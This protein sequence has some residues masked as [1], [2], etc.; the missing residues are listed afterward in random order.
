MES[1]GSGVRAGKG[2]GGINA[3]DAY[4]TMAWVCTPSGILLFSPYPTVSL[5]RP[6]EQRV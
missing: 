2:N 1:V 6:P 5:H 4:T 3:S